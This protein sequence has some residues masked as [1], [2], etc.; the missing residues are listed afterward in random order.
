MSSNTV[1]IVGT[2][3]GAFIY[4]GGKSR[5]DWSISGPHLA[6]WEVSAAHLD[7]HTGRI[8]LGTTHYVYGAT[9][10]AS[11]D[12][13]AKWT[14]MK[15]RPTYPEESGRKVKRIWQLVGSPHDRSTMFCGIDEAG[16]FVSRDSGESWSEV[17]ALTRGEHVKHWSPGNGGLCLH[18]ILIDPNDAKRMWVAISAV[19]VFRTIDGGESWT[20][21]NTGLP[22]MPSG[23]AAIPDL[24][25]PH[26]PVLD[27]R[28]ADTL[29]MQ[30]H[31][32]V[33]RSTN[34][35]DSWHAIENGLPGNF[36]FPMTISRKGEIFICPLQADEQRF[37]KDGRFCVY[38]SRDGGESWQ[39]M[40]SGLPR[41]A[42]VSV[43]RDA[44][45]VDPHDPAGVYVGTAQG[46]V[47]ASTD[48]GERW[49]KLP[50]NLPRI[51]VV[52]AYSA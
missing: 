47:W 45:A 20:S 16:L 8:I 38:R 10:R 13:G 17:S 33:M 24:C 22:T 34:A 31:G 46:E 36:G 2:N 11:D 35:G 30:Y 29:Y 5:R 23:D 14:E 48:A 32:G 25:C 39:P 41:D 27:P 50:G 52:R 3:K 15:A 18:T 9:F 43:L 19:G 1:V 37:F 42:F 26:K 7:S 6:G 40:N 12:L 21:I 44:M 4:R 49:T 51:E 28:N